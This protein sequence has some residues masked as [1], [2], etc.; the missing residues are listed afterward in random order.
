MVQQGVGSEG[1]RKC[2][3]ARPDAALKAKR[4]EILFCIKKGSLT[5][6]EAEKAWFLECSRIGALENHRGY[7][8]WVYVNHKV[9][10]LYWKKGKPENDQRR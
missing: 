8:E 6:P 2:V 3:V 1:V 9:A 5:L 7:I 4:E 10:D